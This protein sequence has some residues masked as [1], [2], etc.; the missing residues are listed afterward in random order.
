MWDAS[1]AFFAE[2][3]TGYT[4]ASRLEVLND[5]FDPIEDYTID[6][7]PV[8]Q[9]TLTNFLSD[10]NIDVDTERGTRRTAEVTII[11]PT[12]EFTPSLKGFQ[13]DSPWAGVVYVNRVIRL[14]RGVYFGDVPEY[15]PVGT[16][17]VDNAQ[18][19]VERNMSLVVLTL[20]D[21][22]KKLTKSIL[23]APKNF[24]SDTPYN[25]I[26]SELV[27]EAGADQPLAPVLSDLSAR[28]AEDK[29]ID[30]KITLEEG[31]SRGERLKE[32]CTAWDIDAYFDP[33]GRFITQDRQSPR[34][35]EVVWHFY[36]SPD[37]DG[38]LVNVSRSFNDD[39]LYNHVVVIGGT[40]QNPIRRERKDEDPSSKFNIQS[41][42]DRVLL[43]KDDK[44][45][46][47]NKVLRRLDEE[48]QMRTKISETTECEVICNPALE[49][50]DVI[51]L[52]EENFARVD[53]TYRLKRFN[54]PMVTSRM[55]IQVADV[56]DEDALYQ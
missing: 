27:N 45:T 20:S 51:K 31:D 7:S 47:V 43:I 13:A 28:A 46:S 41:I 5:D 22:W 1:T 12:A 9:K 25:T 55:K 21:M 14:S 49:G 18:V 11:N 2:L 56:V 26:I 29:K 33:K 48:W 36:S 50:D 39:N 53:Q 38:M 40:V 6:N 37:R 10:G 19:I 8:S 34:D 17:L 23:A 52:T 15:I 3:R 24:P 16:F 4:T 42:G 44:L 54:V 32:Y 35:K 30:T